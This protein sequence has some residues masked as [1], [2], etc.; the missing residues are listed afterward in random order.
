M[1][2]AGT[3]TVGFRVLGE[4]TAVRDGV[5]LELGGR[6][7]RSVVARL[8]VAGGHVVPAELLVAD[9]W[10][11]ASPADALGTLQ[12]HVSHLRRVLEPGRA[13]RT[14]ARLLVTVPPGYALRPADDA[15]DVL[16]AMRLL[17]E[18]DRLAAT[19]PAAARQR[20]SD[21]IDLWRGPAYAEYAD[22]P[23]AAPEAARLDELRL[24]AVERRAAVALD[25]PGGR[26]PLPQLRAHVAEHPLR[27][28]GWRL[29]AL[30]LY[31]AGRQG[32][33]LAALR[34]VRTRLADE[35]GVDP[36]PELRALEEAVLAQAP[37]LLPARGPAPVVGRPAPAAAP[38]A[39]PVA[40]LA[41][42][43]P[44]P[45]GRDAELAALH[46]AADRAAAGSV[47]V[48][49]LA[50]EAG[51]GKTTVL[52]HLRAEHAGRGWTT[53]AV[54]CPETDGAPPGWPW[55][56]ALRS[57]AAATPPA[58]PA[59]LAALLTDH[60]PPETGGDPLGN[61]FRLHRAVGAWLAAVAGRTPLL[62]TVDDLHRADRE[63]T[64]LLLDLLPALV[65]SRVLLVAGH[66]PEESAGLA[67][68]LAALAR[69]SP[70]GLSLRGLDPAAVDALVE[71][72]ALT[73]VDGRTRAAIAERADGN[74]FYVRELLRLVD[75]GADVDAVPGTVRD[76]VRHRL[77]V[78]PARTGTLLKLA[79]VIGRDVDAEVLLA[80]AA[81]AGGGTEEDEEALVEALETA[82]VSG[83]LVEPGPGRLRFVHALVRDILYEDLSSLRR[84]R[85][86]GRVAAVLERLRPDDVTALA[87]HSAAA[88]PG[89]AAAA[90]RWAQAA[91]EL[92][93]RRFAHADAAVMWR[94]AAEATATARPGDR[95]E[96]ARLLAAQAHATA[97][98]GALGEARELRTRALAVLPDPAPAELA[99]EVLLSSDVPTFWNAW[100]DP[101]DDRFVGRTEQAVA[102]LP[103]GDPQRARLLAML[104]VELEERHEDR[105][106]GASAEALSEARLGGDPLALAHALTV[107]QFHAVRGRDRSEATALGT[108]LLDLAQREGFGVFEAVAR[109]VLLQD[110]CAVLDLDAA[111]THAAEAERL[112]SAYGLPLLHGIARCY[113]G[114]RA[115]VAGRTAEAEAAYDVAE[116]A[117]LDAG[118]Y[119]AVARALR[120]TT[121]LALQLASP[122]AWRVDPAELE[123]LVPISPELAHET[124][125]LALVL[126]G[127]TEEARSLGPPRG[128]AARDLVTPF[129][130]YCRGLVGLALGDAART[131]EAEAELL[132][133]RDTVCGTHTA[134]MA[135]GPTATLLARLAAARGDREAAEAHRAVA[136]A[137]AERTGHPGWIAAAR[138]ALD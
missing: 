95:A 131:A 113:A 91:A 8:L 26:D 56:A 129:L 84:T 53:L 127:R 50:G 39:A 100:V 105:A 128:Q 107:R 112:S 29:L 82:L 102:G 49:L 134:Q 92:A 24:T 77:G 44:R 38:A 52:D 119:P 45:V 28:E 17:D 90:A 75:S 20:Y 4:V 58:D 10:R 22:E 15:V 87:H 13:P 14:P 61:R 32:E 120:L 18:G 88:G 62:V 111:D 97:L 103:P 78:L 136:V 65:G 137:V 86:H 7:Q 31:R 25:A 126:A 72:W 118:Y 70:V 33:A 19:D 123:A 132:P 1:D 114:L 43:V 9:L 34:E 36:G 35:L 85:L 42:E 48:A 80:A 68:V 81:P 76:V 67:D 11:G 138:A 63:T 73:P 55:A 106:A 51:S 116:R 109:L 125:A 12:A 133:Y 57:L 89:S 98:A 60:A 27:E 41:P 83:L 40:V 59:P 115:A 37:S 30:G 71:D 108:E 96:L 110:T 64:A 104:A 124:R 79:A 54:S 2:V 69:R 46:A 94:R 3:G 16:E 66:R 74:P 101:V 135:F 6:R 99:A 21:A 23:W 93:G 117:L 130:Q 47:E 121:Q 5:A 122:D